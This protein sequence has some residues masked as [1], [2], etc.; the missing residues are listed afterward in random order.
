MKSFINLSVENFV[1]YR[2]IWCKILFA[3]ILSIL[4]ALFCYY[5]YVY[6]SKLVVNEPKQFLFCTWHILEFMR[7]NPYTNTKNKQQY[8]HDFFAKYE[9]NFYC[10]SKMLQ[11][12]NRSNITLKNRQ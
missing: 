8:K 5:M 10:I 9:N 12:H 3:A 11:V 2:I 7:H 4:Y 1:I 6:D